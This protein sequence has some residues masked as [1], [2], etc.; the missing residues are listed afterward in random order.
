MVS[1]YTTTGKELRFNKSYLYVLAVFIAFSYSTS[2]L[3]EHETVE[4]SQHPDPEI[5]AALIKT[6]NESESFLDRFDAEVWLVDMSARMSRYMTNAEERLEFLKLVHMEASR[7]DLSPEL[8]LSV[9][10]VESLFDRFAISRTGAQGF[11]QIMP[12]WKKEIGRTGDNLMRTDTNLRY[13][14]TILKHYLD[15][16]KGNLMRALARYNGSIGKMWYPERV[17]KAWK[18]YWFVNHI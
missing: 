10:H 17:M 2:S 4:S 14:C 11:M 5:R 12:F 16:E 15:R 6:V 1:T 7:A 8:V 9:I 13:G 3:A 18:K